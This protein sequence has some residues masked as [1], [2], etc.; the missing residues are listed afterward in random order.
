MGGTWLPEEVL[1]Q[2]KDGSPRRTVRLREGGG[3]LREPNAARRLE[4]PVRSGSA[5]Q[6]TLDLA[7][8]GGGDP[9]MLSVRTSAIGHGRLGRPW[10]TS[11]QAIDAPPPLSPRSNAQLSTTTEKSKN[12]AFLADFGGGWLAE[13][14]PGAP[15]GPGADHKRGRRM[16]ALI[17]Q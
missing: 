16:L 17:A 15:D 1:P 3:R 14:G 12:F 9:P 2:S 5:S 10:D 13:A 11:P 6:S 7:S 4:R 8:P